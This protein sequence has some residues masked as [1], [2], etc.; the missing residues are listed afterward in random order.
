MLPLATSS[1]HSCTITCCTSHLFW[2][3]PHSISCLRLWPGGKLAVEVLAP[4]LGCVCWAPSV[5]TLIVYMELCWMQ[6]VKPLVRERWQ[7][8]C[9]PRRPRLSGVAYHPF[10]FTSLFTPISIIATNE[11]AVHM[12]TERDSS[13]DPCGYACFQ[14]F[15][16]LSPQSGVIQ[17]QVKLQPT[18]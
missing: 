13:S 3:T 5:Q 10:N 4:S 17:H 6:S 16:I 14:C 11:K 9:Y 12:K 18:P 15:D 8:L 1:S 2:K 7:P